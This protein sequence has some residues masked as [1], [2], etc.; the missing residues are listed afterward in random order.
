[1]CCTSF[2]YI[3]VARQCLETA[4]G[5]EHGTRAELELPAELEDIVSDMYPSLGI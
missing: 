2:I 1:M 5:I 3:L 4:Y